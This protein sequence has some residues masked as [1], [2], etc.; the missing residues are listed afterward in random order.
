MEQTIWKGRRWSAANAYLKPALGRK[1]LT[2]HNGLATRVIWQAD[3]AV[4]IE[5]M[6]GNTR[7][8]LRARKE[9]IL[10]ASVFNSA[11]LLMLSGIGAKADLDWLGIDVLR[12]RT[13]RRSKPSG[14]SGRSISRC[15]VRGRLRFAS[16]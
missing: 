6:R 9:V 10:S 4:G 7:C 12:D 3:R 13:R 11:K 2:V 1:N 14:S 16:I 8:M 5:F 15:G